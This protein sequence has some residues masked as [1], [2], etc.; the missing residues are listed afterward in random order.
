MTQQIISF[1]WDARGR[2]L[3]WTNAI[4]NLLLMNT[5]NVINWNL[6]SYYL[7]LRNLFQIISKQL[8]HVRKLS[9]GLEINLVLSGDRDEKVWNLNCDN[10]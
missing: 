8:L 6:K 3:L 4:S 2:H 9:F 1:W 10:C 5:S 7:V